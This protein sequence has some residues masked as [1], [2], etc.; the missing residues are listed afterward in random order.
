MELIDQVEAIARTH[1]AERVET[2]VLQIGS[3]AGV[4]PSLL[5]NAFE[6]ARLGT[7]AEHAELRTE[8]V[9]PRIRCQVCSHEAD[10]GPSDLRCPACGGTDTALIAGEEMILARVEL[11]QPAD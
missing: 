6:I 3:L 8:R 9:E 1:N 4:E 10:A 2:I 11:L 7:V 5:E